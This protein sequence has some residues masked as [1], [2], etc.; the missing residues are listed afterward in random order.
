MSKTLEVSDETYA[1][2]KEQ[3]GE[4]EMFEV[5]EL[6]DLIGKAFYFRTVTYHWVGKVEKR[7]GKILELSN[8][9][10][11]ASSGRFMQAIKDGILDEVEPV[12]I[13][14]VNLDTVTDICPWKHPLPTSQK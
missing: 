12:G 11:V 8:A 9:S 13:A 14:L 5:D 4:H 1:K 3:L 6:D 2:I 10:W 7:I